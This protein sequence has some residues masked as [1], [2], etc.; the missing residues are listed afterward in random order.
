MLK[1]AN[2]LFLFL[3]LFISTLFTSATA[4]PQVEERQSPFG[5]FA[6]VGPEYYLQ[7]KVISGDPSKNGLYGKPQFSQTLPPKHH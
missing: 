1:M 6:P 5:P 7:T 3:V 4:A 2:C